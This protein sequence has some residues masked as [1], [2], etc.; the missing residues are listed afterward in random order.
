MNGRPSL[1]VYRGGTFSRRRIIKCD[2]DENFGAL[3]FSSEAAE[4]DAMHKTLFNNAKVRSCV[5]C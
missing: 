5:Q 4:V 2:T 1:A 3:T